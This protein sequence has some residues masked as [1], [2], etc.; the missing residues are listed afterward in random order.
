MDE[1]LA[2][3]HWPA[4]V[5]H[6]ELKIESE[7][8]WPDE[9]GSSS[10]A[11]DDY[12]N[13]PQLRVKQSHVYD[14]EYLGLPGSRYTCER[15]EMLPYMAYN[16]PARLMSDEQRKRLKDF[17]VEPVFE[18][19]QNLEQALTVFA[20]AH[21]LSK[22]MWRKYSVFGV[23]HD[24]MNKRRKDHITNGQAAQAKK[25][26]APPQTIQFYQCVWWGAEKI[27]AGDL[28][29]LAA[30]WYS[31][32]SGSALLKLFVD[33]K[34]VP[35]P[36]AKINKASLDKPVLFALA[37]IYRDPE[38]KRLR[39]MGS[40]LEIL[41]DNERNAGSGMEA[42]TP[43]L[44]GD[45]DKPNSTIPRFLPSLPPG[46]SFK[47]LRGVPEGEEFEFDASLLAG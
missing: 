47:R 10:E 2:I 45:V 24:P 21:Q 9:N 31:D 8:Y 12:D 46:R 39:I 7:A 26:E 33:S 32:G 41:D 40:F 16:P 35:I 5:R 6:R 30:T 20:Y 27:W 23:I 28:V 3:T 13:L 17:D 1:T 38:R 4:V 25:I 29:R 43:I 36:G 19:M 18:E 37:H 15:E 11:G 44:I 22:H 42:S 14:L 34:I